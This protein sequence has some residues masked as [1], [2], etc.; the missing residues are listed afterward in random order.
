M[1]GR[2]YLR[3]PKS[4][5]AKARPREAEEPDEEVEDPAETGRRHEVIGILTAAA[6]VLLSLA[7]WSYDARGGENWIGPV[8]TGLASLLATA[9][10]VAAW[11]LPVELALATVRLF[12]RRLTALG[13]ATVAST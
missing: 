10:G 1:W 9:F 11:L 2:S 4:T 13:F 5:A 7:L 8:G 12:S 6:T 3:S